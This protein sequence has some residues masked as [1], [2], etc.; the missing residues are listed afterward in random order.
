MTFAF[1]VSVS[2]HVWINNIE[3]LLNSKLLVKTNTEEEYLAPGL[4]L[5]TDVEH[6]KQL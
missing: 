6:A 3:Q 1:V 2:G 5:S 4:V